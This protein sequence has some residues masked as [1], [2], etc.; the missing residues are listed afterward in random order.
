MRASSSLVTGS[1]ACLW[2]DF[3]FAVLSDRWPWSDGSCGTKLFDHGRVDPFVFREL[4][5][6]RSIGA[7]LQM[8]LH[9]FR[10]VTEA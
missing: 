9:A 8:D 6:E 4:E 2:R 7:V 3:S 10:V 1:S 5:Y